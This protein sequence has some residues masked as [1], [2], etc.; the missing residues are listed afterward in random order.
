VNCQCFGG[1]QTISCEGTTTCTHVIVNW[2]NALD[3][4]GFIYPCPGPGNC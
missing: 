1:P 4:D 2:H 3:C